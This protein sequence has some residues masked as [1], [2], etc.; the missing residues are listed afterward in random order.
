MSWQSLRF[1][2]APRGRGLRSPALRRRSQASTRGPRWLAVSRASSWG[3]SQ[4][5]PSS[6]RG[7]GPGRR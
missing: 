4:C 2:S 3:Q 7:P 1:R 6:R 5:A